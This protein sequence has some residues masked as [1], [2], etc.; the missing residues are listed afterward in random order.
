L[1]HELNSLTNTKTE[2]LKQAPMIHNFFSAEYVISEKRT[3]NKKSLSI[4]LV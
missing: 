4:D 1:D 3:E 2:L